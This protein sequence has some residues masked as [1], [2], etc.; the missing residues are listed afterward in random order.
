MELIRGRERDCGQEYLVRVSGEE[1]ERLE[2]LVRASKPRC[3]FSSSRIAL[4]F[5]PRQKNARC[6]RGGVVDHT[7]AKSPGGDTSA[8]APTPGNDRS[9]RNAAIDHRHDLRRAVRTERLLKRKPNS[10]ILFADIHDCSTPAFP[11]NFR[12]EKYSEQD[13]RITI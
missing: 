5:R 9:L 8:R 4:I 7:R 3:L 1:R 6:L 13:I 12:T 2:S 11:Y 10:A